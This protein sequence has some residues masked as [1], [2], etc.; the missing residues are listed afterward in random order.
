V[1]T[2]TLHG[3]MKAARVHVGAAAGTEVEVDAQNTYQIFSVPA[4]T[5]VWT[6]L[7]RVITA[8]SASV[9][10]TCGD[11]DDVDGWLVS[12]KIAPTVAETLGIYKSPATATVEA[13]S[14][15]K[16]YLAADTI[17]LVIAGAT[18]AA[19]LLEVIVIYSSATFGTT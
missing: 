3:F 4:G 10:M 2:G 16:K 6:V 9:T 13:Y 14:G 12:A 17:D 15:G 19:G 8:F 1:G 5:F 18:P 7:T 11:G